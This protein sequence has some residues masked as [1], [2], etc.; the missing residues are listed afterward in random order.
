MKHAKTLAVSG[1][2]LIGATMAGGSD[3]LAQGGIPPCATLPNPVFMGGTTAVLPAIRHFGAKLKAAGIITLLWNENSE[4]CSSVAQLA[5][6]PKNLVR[7]TFSSY[8]EVGT[9]RTSTVVISNCAGTL[10]QVPDLVINDTFWMSCF[11]SYGSTTSGV[12]QPLPP[13]LKEFLG[14][15]QGL[16]PIVAKSYQYYFDI[17]AEELLDIYAC[18]ASG[19]ILTFLNDSYVYNYNGETSGIRELFARSIGAPNGQILTVGSGNSNV[20]AETMIQYVSSTILPRATIGYTSTEFYD[21]SRDV[22]NALKVRGVN[23]L[24]AYLPDTDQTSLDKINIREG[25]YTIQGALKFVTPVDANGVP[26]NPG[27]KKII[28]W[29]Q[30][31]PAADPLPFDVNEIYAERGVVPQCAMR[32]TKDSD[33]ATFR[34]YADPSPCHCSFEILATG[35][36]CIPGCTACTDSST[37][38]TGKTCSHGYC[39]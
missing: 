12:A 16:V 33:M 6:Q 4:G 22:V 13:N 18:G 34:R 30:G 10:D 14:P 11:Y 26:V 38:P 9:G 7:P 29:M 32:V 39:E 21:E 2:L 24:K 5:T 20:T 3:V 36:K 1:I 35:K 27:A 23:Q 8:D 31:N 15:V 19:K 17:M 25:R 37:C 28:D